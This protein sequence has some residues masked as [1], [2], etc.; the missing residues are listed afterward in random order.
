M[1][2][3]KLWIG[4]LRFAD[5][6]VKNL[7]V[8]V[9]NSLRLQVKPVSNYYLTFAPNEEEEREEEREEEGRN[10]RLWVK[11]RGEVEQ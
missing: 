10:N 7:C 9:D 5:S 6:S 3:L 8:T 1:V 2:P 11:P 4:P